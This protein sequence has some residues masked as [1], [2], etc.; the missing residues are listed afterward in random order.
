M[1]YKYLRAWA[2]QSVEES[3]QVEMNYSDLS[4]EQRIEAIRNINLYNKTFD[5]N[6][7]VSEWTWLVTDLSVQRGYRR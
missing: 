5:V 4:A 3:L 1:D 6:E 2:K 7:F